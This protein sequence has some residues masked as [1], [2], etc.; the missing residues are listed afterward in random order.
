MEEYKLTSIDYA[1]LIQRGAF[2]QYNV[3]LN[4][5]Q[6]QKTLF[7]VYGVCLATLDTKIFDDDSPKAWPFGPVFPRVYKKVS[8]KRIDALHPNAIESFRNRQDILNVV[9]QAIDRLHGMTGTQLSEWSHRVGSPWYDT[10]FVENVP[11]GAFQNKYGTQITDDII[12]SYFSIPDNRD[13][14]R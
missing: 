1:I 10:L 2:N 9:L 11:D 6:L 7:Y 5:T 3:A 13:N 12:R 8:T 14:V 4:M